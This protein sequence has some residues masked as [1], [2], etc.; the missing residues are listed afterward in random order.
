MSAKLIDR[1]DV[2]RM[3]VPAPPCRVELTPEHLSSMRR[4]LEG[5]V[6][7]YEANRCDR[8]A[9]DGVGPTAAYDVGVKRA[10]HEALD[11]LVVG[12]FGNCSTCGEAIAIERLQVVP[13]ARRCATCQQHEEGGW[14]QFER[15]VA[16]VVR[17]LVGEPQGRLPLRPEQ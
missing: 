10:V 5:F 4:S 16:S 2:T 3:G 6:E 14:N 17:Q 11:D 13:Y 15:F 12:A 9:T 1:P 7:A 8:I